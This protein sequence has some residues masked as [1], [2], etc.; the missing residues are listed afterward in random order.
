MDTDRFDVLLHEEDDD[1]WA[2]IATAVEKEFPSARV[3]PVIAGAEQV[4]TNDDDLRNSVEQAISEAREAEST[5]K[6]CIG[7][8]GLTKGSLSVNGLLIPNVCP[9]CKLQADADTEARAK[10]MAQAINRFMGLQ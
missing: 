2:K 1:R 5:Y 9:P 10:M 3:V 7:C 8:G 4:L 6:V